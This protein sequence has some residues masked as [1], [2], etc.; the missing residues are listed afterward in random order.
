MVSIG[1]KRCSAAFWFAVPVPV[2]HNQPDRRLSLCV[3]ILLRAKLPPSAGHRQSFLLCE[4][5]GVGARR[6]ETDAPEPQAGAFQ[7]GLRANCGIRMAEKGCV[8]RQSEIQ[9]G[10]SHLRIRR[11]RPGRGSP[12]PLVP[13]RFPGDHKQTPTLMSVRPGSKPVPP[14]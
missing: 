8:V 6:V 3:P 7:H 4:H 1:K 10:K 12:L 2:P 5:A 11:L 9:E 14:W 13:A